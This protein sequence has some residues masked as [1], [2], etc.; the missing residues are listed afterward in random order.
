[1]TGATEATEGPSEY[2]PVGWITA[3]TLTKAADT[4]VTL[5]GL[6][7]GAVEQNPVAV[8]VMEAVGPVVGLVSLSVLT[9]A[10]TVGV[11]E[12]AA[13]RVTSRIGTKA[14]R[15]TAYG[16]LVVTW[17]VVVSHNVLVVAGTG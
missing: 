12:W 8:A 14:V 17:L 1:M 15:L 10:V 3:L 2:S 7:R 4:V 6:T 9:V 11:V 13:R 5:D 16:P